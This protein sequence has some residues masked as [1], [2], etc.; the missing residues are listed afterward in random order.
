[1][2][3]LWMVSCSHCV[4]LTDRMRRSWTACRSSF[5]YLAVAER[6]GEQVGRGNRVLHGDIDAHTADR[7]HRVRSIADADQPGP[8]P[9]SQSVDTDAEE[10]DAIP[11]LQFGDAIG[12]QRRHFDD[13]LAESL[14][15]VRL[16]A[17]NS[18]LWNDVSALPVTA[19]I[20]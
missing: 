15:A 8:P 10:L 1:M 12:Q 17:L 4:K 3:R 20:A 6:A 9:F 18:A 14:K 2:I 5:R 19:A 16:H 7:R 13:P 11:A